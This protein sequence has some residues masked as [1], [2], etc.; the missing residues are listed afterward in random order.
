M[1]APRPVRCPQY[2]TLPEILKGM[3]TERE[4]AWLPDA[5][6]NT[7][8]DDLTLPDADSED[9]AEWTD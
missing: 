4:Y 3:V 1:P 6:K 2:G 9:P 8:I 5:A 7:L